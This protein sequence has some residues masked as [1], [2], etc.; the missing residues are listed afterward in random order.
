MFDHT[1]RDRN[2]HIYIT[3]FSIETLDSLWNPLTTEKELGGGEIA[4]DVDPLVLLNTPNILA[5][6]GYEKVTIKFLWVSAG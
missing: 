6:S 2:T 1:Y 3:V 5:E 4:S